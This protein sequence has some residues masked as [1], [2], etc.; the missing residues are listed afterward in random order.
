VIE[1]RLAN[2]SSTFDRHSKKVLSVSHDLEGHEHPSQGSCRDLKQ[3][4]RSNQRAAHVLSR[5][6]VQVRATVRSGQV[7]AASRDAGIGP[8]WFVTPARSEAPFRAEGLMVLPWRR[9]AKSAY[10]A[11]QSQETG[12]HSK[13]VPYR[14][15]SSLSPS[16]VS[17]CTRSVRGPRPNRLIPG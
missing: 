6:F 4:Q 11:P 14:D 1:T 13:E 8:L 17:R 15:D 5:E 16:R 12:Q 10:D 2:M 7:S 9:T 3:R